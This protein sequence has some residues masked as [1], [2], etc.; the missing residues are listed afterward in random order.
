MFKISAE[1]VKM[2][3]QLIS[4]G[5]AHVLIIYNTMHLIMFVYFW[6]RKPQITLKK[7]T[8]HAKVLQ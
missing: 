8:Y 1:V 3:Y 2:V 7:K 4:E 6:T 5:Y